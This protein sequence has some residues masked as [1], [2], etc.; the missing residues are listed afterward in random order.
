MRYTG[1]LTI[2]KPAEWVVLYQGYV[3]LGA[4]V[5]ARAQ[6]ARLPDAMGTMLLYLYEHG[7]LQA[8][9]SKERRP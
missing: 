7:L 4:E 2:H 6:H 3:L 1:L 8:S 5:K 9:N